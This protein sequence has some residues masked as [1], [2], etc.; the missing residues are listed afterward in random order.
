MAGS[1][2]GREVLS[3]AQSCRSALVAGYWPASFWAAVLGGGRLLL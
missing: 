3:S 1:L 2:G